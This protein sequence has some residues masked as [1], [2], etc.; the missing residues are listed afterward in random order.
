MEFQRVLVAALA[1]VA[2]VPAA[3]GVAPRY[4]S[5]AVPAAAGV[6]TPQCLAAAPVAAE[7]GRLEVSW[8]R[9]VPG[10]FLRRPGV[11]RWSRR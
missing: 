5:E 1:A 11:R 4:R 7:L 10:E 3:A 2:A 9:L 6:A 8:S